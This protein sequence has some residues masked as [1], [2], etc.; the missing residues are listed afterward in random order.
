MSARRKV[1]TE[2]PRV[3]A[4]P[5]LG[6]TITGASEQ[7]IDPNIMRIEYT[8]MLNGGELV[9]VEI[10]DPNFSKFDQIMGSDYFETSRNDSKAP[11]T[12]TTDIRWDGNDQL[13]ITPPLTHAVV[14]CWPEGNSNL[15]TINI[16]AVDFASYYLK[17]GDAGGYCYTGTVQQVIQQIVQKYSRGQIQLTMDTK[18]KD[19]KY[20]KW[21]QYRLDPKTLIV[22]LLEWSTPLT[23]HQTRWLLYPEDKKLRIVEQGEMDHLNRS[24]YEWRGE[25]GTPGGAGDIEE[26][27]FIGDNALQMYEN[28]MVTGGISAVSGAYFDPSQYKKNKQKVF[29][30]DQNTPDKH[31]AKTPEIG[32]VPSYRSYKR[33]DPDADPLT[34]AVGWSFTSPIPEMSAGDMGIKYDQYMDGRARGLYLAFTQTLLRARFRVPGHYIWGCSEG[35]GIDTI[36]IKITTGDDSMPYFFDGN[37]MVYGFKHVVAADRWDTDLFACRYD[38]DSNAIKEGAGDG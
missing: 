22:S 13:R 34:G 31:I 5:Y 21:W 7:V 9:Q 11:I 17:G 20:N 36:Q 8:A 37:W 14:A 3:T 2:R 38:Y 10:L 30:G 24:T 12:L 16:L 19:S 35:L 27:E 6:L 25:G 23:Q 32:S 4:K 29:V 28:Q 1:E 26:W 15:A 18:T 33:A